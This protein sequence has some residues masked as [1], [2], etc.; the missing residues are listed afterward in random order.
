MAT[1]NLA[2]F[3]PLYLGHYLD[4]ETPDFHYEIYDDLSDG[5]INFIEII[6]FRGS[7]KSTIASLALPLWSAITKKKNFIVILSDSFKQAKLIIA[8]IIHELENNED[9]IK[10][11]G[12]FQSREEWTATSIVLANKVRIIAQ[13]RGMKFRGLRHLQYR[14]DLIVCD[15]VENIENVRTLEQRDKTNEWFS[16]DVIPALDST[17]GKLVIIG[18]LLHTD[19][20]LARIK[21]QIQTNKRGKYREFPIIR[22]DKALWNS[23]FPLDVIAQKKIDVG[24]RFFLREFLLKIVPDEGQVITK[25]EY[26]NK[27][28]KLKTIAIGTDLAISKKETADYSAIVVAGLGDDGKYYCLHHHSGRWNFN[29][30]L[31]EINNTFVR[32]H[33]AFP[34]LPCYLGFEDVA[35]QRAAIEEGRRRYGLPIKSIKRTTD[36]RARLQTQEPYYSSGQIMFRSK[37]DEDVVIQI[38]NFGVEMHDDLMDACEMAFDLLIKQVKPDILWL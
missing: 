2:W 14:P 7:A 9:L 36:K 37:G 24:T 26:Y 6:G 17:S 22:D 19:S 33:K 25:V 38:L 15:D 21:K 10:D 20:L 30:F 27:L 16:S 1:D 28:P 35:Y 32:Y 8:N 13:S 5:N 11:F 34:D 29:E 23:K 4:S 31:D 18:T 12:P 3:P